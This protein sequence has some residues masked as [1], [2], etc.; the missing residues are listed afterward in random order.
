[1][2]GGS[3]KHERVAQRPHTCLLSVSPEQRAEVA[4]R[5]SRT[6]EDVVYFGAEGNRFL[7][8]L[9]EDGH[10]PVAVRPGPTSCGALATLRSRTSALCVYDNGTL[11]GAH[12]GGIL[13][14]HDTAVSAPAVFDDGTLRITRVA[15]GLRLAGELDI[16]NRHGLSA[17]MATGVDVIDVRS[18]RFVDA[19][20]IAAMYAAAHGRVRLLYPQPV[21]RRVITLVDPQARRLVCEGVGSG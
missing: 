21:P 3:D 5:F 14:G 18:L 1:V 6:G 7:R 4:A 19:G 17:A 13:A 10:E 16:S 8:R 15:N 20:G 2:P 9:R 12:R 11:T